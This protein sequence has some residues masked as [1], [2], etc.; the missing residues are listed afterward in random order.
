MKILVFIYIYLYLIYTLCGYNVLTKLRI[1]K[2]P[3]YINFDVKSSAFVLRRLCKLSNNSLLLS[4]YFVELPTIS[5]YISATLVHIVIFIS[6][7]VKWGYKDDPLCYI[8]HVVSGVPIIIYP[9]FYPLINLPPDNTPL[10][11][12]SILCLYYFLQDL[13]Y[14][15][16]NKKR[17]TWVS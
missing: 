11:T 10:I 4:A 16:K 12:I 8:S 2:I 7:L 3:D 13:I 17:V 14:I 9:C 15:N 5:L 1:R 6:Y